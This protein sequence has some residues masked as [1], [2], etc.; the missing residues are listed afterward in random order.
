MNGWKS[1]PNDRSPRSDMMGHSNNVMHRFR[2]LGT[3][4]L[5][6]SVPSCAWMSTY[7]SE[8]RVSIERI[9]T[10][11]G[12]IVS[13]N[14]WRDGEQLS[15]R[16]QVVSNPVTKGPIDGHVD[17]EI[18]SPDRTSRTCV[19]ASPRLRAR[20]VR[21]PYLAPFVALPLPGSEVRVWHHPADPHT[22]C[23]PSPSSTT[24]LDPSMPSVTKA[25]F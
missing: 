24:T 16:G 17:I 7:V 25:S 6:M 23:A 19:I 13:A 1:A 8:P 11:T 3:A 21:K 9:S 5:A 4:V 14:F 12:R 20:K 15:L 10:P 22:N 18:L 2:W